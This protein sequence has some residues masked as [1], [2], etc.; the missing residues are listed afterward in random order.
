MPSVG[1]AP[2][3]TLAA[4]TNVSASAASS[5]RINLTWGINS[6]ATGYDIYRS[7]NGASFSNIATIN[8]SIKGSYSD[9]SLAASTTYF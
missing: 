8:S 9:T 6:T 5:T 3:T 4:P 1:A 7:T 2:S